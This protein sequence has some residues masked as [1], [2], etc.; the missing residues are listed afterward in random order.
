MNKNKIIPLLIIALVLFKAAYLFMQPSCLSWDCGYYLFSFK[1][2]LFNQKWKMTLEDPFRLYTDVWRAIALYSG[3]NV[4]FATKLAILASDVIFL[5]G[6]YFL[7]K[8]RLSL[9]MLLFALVL[10]NFSSG[11]LRMWADQ[12]RQY[13]VMALL[14]YLVYFLEKGK[15]ELVGILLFIMIASHISSLLIPVIIL[16]YCLYRRDWKQLVTIGLIAGLLLAFYFI[17][18]ETSLDSVAAGAFS[19]LSYMRNFLEFSV[20]HG[21]QVNTGGINPI[22]INLANLLTFNSVLLVVGFL[23]IINADLTEKINLFL[24]IMLICLIPLLFT[25]ITMGRAATLMNFP[26]MLFALEFVKDLDKRNQMIYL[27]L[28]SIFIAYGVL[29]FANFKTLAN[30]E[31]IGMIDLPE[32]STIILPSTRGLWFVKFYTGNRYDVITGR[33][34]FP[35]EATIMFTD[36]ENAIRAFYSLK[37]ELGV[38][39]AYVYYSREFDKMFINQSVI[40]YLKDSYVLSEV[41]V[42]GKEEVLIG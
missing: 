15:N 14:P 39:T 32:N 42:N 37:D 5:V 27:I 41:F 8:D 22:F 20:E 30:P 7:L 31:S 36:K 23:G 1:H 19:E 25:N 17:T 16:I 29:N 26:L 21:E 3:M 40:D 10:A 11:F 18:L 35:D 4:V 2:S 13:F 34:L 24:I 6:I 9:K 33:F 12:L 38:K 28:L